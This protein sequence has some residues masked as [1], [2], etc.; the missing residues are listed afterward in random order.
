MAGE[1]LTRRAFGSQPQL[2]R[3]WSSGSAASTAILGRTVAGYLLTPILLAYQAT[4]YLFATRVLGWW[5]PPQSLSDPGVVA[6]SV[7]WL[8]VIADAVQFAFWEELLVRA[9]PIAGAALIGDRL[10]RR[11]LFVGIALILQAMLFSA[12]HAT[13]VSQPAYA[14]AVEL[15]LPSLGFGCLYLAFG[16]LPAIIL[17]L[18]NDVVWLGLPLFMSS[19]HGAWI[20]LALVIGLTL[21]PLWIVVG[22]RLRRAEWFELPVEARNEHW[23]SRRRQRAVPSSFL[24]CQHE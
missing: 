23:V 5:I 15:L 12:S 8:R 20:D 4:F 10:G 13:V 24:E 1:S 16:L 21:I 9:V 18:A 7:P 17:H 6:S 3:T 2:W 14:R 19:G 22:A 11:R